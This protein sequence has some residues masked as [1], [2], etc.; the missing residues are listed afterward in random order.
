MFD[1]LKINT[2]WFVSFKCIVN[3]KTISGNRIIKD[4]RPFLAKSRYY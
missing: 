1:F 2:Y 4:T 3:D